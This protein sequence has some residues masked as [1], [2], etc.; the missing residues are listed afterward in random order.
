MNLYIHVESKL[1]E[2]EA[3]SLLALAAAERGHRVLVGHLK[4]VFSSRGSLLPPGIF[5]DK[6]LT[7]RDG[8][9]ARHQRL[10]AD[11]F[12]VTSQDEENGMALLAYED[13][14]RK[15]YSPRM[16]AQASMAFA[17]GEYE[18]AQLRQLFP[19]HSDAV[20]VSGSP[21]VDLWRREF[22]DFYL[23][24]PRPGTEGRD[25]YVLVSSNFNAL[26]RVPFWRMMR[27][28]RNAGYFDGPDDPFE[29]DEYRKMVDEYRVLGPLVRGVRLLARTLPELLVVVRPHPVE[30]V[31]TW[32]ALLGPVPNVL[33]SRHGSISRWIRGAEALIHNGCTSGFEAAVSGVP[34]ISFQPEGVGRE[35][36]SNRL[37]RAVLSEAE[38]VESVEEVVAPPDRPTRDAGDHEALL[39]A[40]F[41]NLDG[42]FAVDRI[43]D[44]WEEL[45]Q[46]GLGA[47][48]D[49]RRV[50]A[51]VRGR[52]VMREARR[53][54]RSAWPAGRWAGSD[55]GQGSSPAAPRP[56]RWTVSVAD[57][58]AMVAGFRA[59]LDRFHDVEA[60]RIEPGLIEFH[61]R[62]KR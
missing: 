40:W 17:W 58:E 34:L 15:R 52:R 31:E 22:D 7:P 21:R 20:R 36:P 35:L 19:A 9:L 38:L 62:G 37:G 26:N 47:Q 45:E 3:R 25:R 61:P 55:P 44:A 13:F 1:R 16:L 30:D 46:P 49:A 39:A 60:K 41:A 29:F 32:R 4:R 56:R 48:W 57:L 5:H 24:Q 42:A 43:V 23:R 53:R 12:V 50:S 8:K 33:V 27:S 6:S 54:V 51:A 28:L 59:T 11:G 2:L 18:A 14:A 10:V